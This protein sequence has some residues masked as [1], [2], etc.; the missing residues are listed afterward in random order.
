MMKTKYSDL[1]PFG[2]IKLTKEEQEFIERIGNFVRKYPNWRE[3][4]QEQEILKQTLQDLK[5]T[6]SDQK[7]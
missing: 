1:D 7:D 6:L 3:V 2:K 4:L 5:R